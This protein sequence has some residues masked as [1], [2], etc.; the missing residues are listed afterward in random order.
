MGSVGSQREPIADATTHP[1]EEQD[2]AGQKDERGDD[3]VRRHGIHPERRLNRLVDGHE[4]H[5][6]V[7][8]VV[9]EEGVNVE[10]AAVQQTFQS[11]MKKV[12]RELSQIEQHTR[13]EDRNRKQR[14]TGG[15]RLRNR[16]STISNLPIPETDGKTVEPLPVKADNQGSSGAIT[17]NWKSPAWLA[18]GRAPTGGRGTGNARSVA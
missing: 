7:P 15:K 13:G 16:T 17:G 8:R 1:D 6:G 5:R 12:S 14:F 2:D 10:P 4:A 18:W 3:G 9:D 11:S